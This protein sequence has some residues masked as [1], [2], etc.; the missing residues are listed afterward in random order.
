MISTITKYEYYFNVCA[1]K[2]GCAANLINQGVSINHE[3][4][5]AM[6]EWQVVGDCTDAT[7]KWDGEDLRDCKQPLPQANSNE[8]CVHL[9]IV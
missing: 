3:D 1:G 5:I 2:R 8:L 4:E 7:C 9:R 6:V